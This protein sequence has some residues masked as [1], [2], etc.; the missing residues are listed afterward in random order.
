MGDAA[1][2]GPEVALK[3]ALSPEVREICLPLIVGSPAPFKALQKKLFPDTQL[4]PVSDLSQVRPETADLI[5]FPD[6]SEAW[7]SELLYPG[8]RFEHTFTVI[9]TYTYICVPHIATGMQGTIIVE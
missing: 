1:G 4:R 7:A 2:V 5:S 6:G 9:G 3:A 8:E